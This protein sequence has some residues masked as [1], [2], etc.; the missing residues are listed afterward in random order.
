MVDMPC[1]ESQQR[2]GDWGRA[3]L[4]VDLKMVI[5]NSISSDQSQIHS[6][7]KKKFV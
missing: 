1:L 2:T 6:F 5:N 4:S 3:S 7:K